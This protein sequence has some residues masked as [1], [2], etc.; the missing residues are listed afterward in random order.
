MLLVTGWPI[1]IGDC[2]FIILLPKITNTNTA[3]ITTA[4][5]GINIF[6][7]SHG[8]CCCDCCWYFLVVSR[9]IVEVAGVV[10]WLLAIL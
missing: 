2:R 9:V 1:A 4:I 7:L 10:V 3:S 5:I 6:D 8:F